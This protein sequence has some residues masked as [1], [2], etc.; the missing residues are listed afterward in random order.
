[1]S[2][3]RISRKAFVRTGALCG[4]GAGAALSSA[5]GSLEAQH[6]AEELEI[7]GRRSREER[8]VKLG[9][10]IARESELE[11]NSSLRFDD[12][13]TGGPAVL[14]RRE[15]GGFVAY[16][17]L[18]THERCPVFYRPENRR[19][20]CPCHGAEFD[21]A[22]DGVPDTGPAQAPLPNVTVEVRDGNVVRV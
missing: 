19:I 20:V 14:V 1:M 2:R 16:H 12:A 13:E 17:A 8:A 3:K 18:C 6:T 9:D 22:R 11:V 10:V 7:E 15:D 21:P 4:L 5:C